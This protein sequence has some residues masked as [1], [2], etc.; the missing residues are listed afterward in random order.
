MIKVAMIGA[1]SVEFSKRLTGDILAYPEFKNATLTY[2]DIDQERLQVGAAL[3][4][5][6]AKTLGSN[7]TIEAT[8][9]LRQALNG[10]D[11]VITM[12]LVGGFDSVLADFEIPRKFG[13]RQ[14]I[15][16]TAGPAAVMKALRL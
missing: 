3:C 15:A 12:L 5:K 6:M 14:T 7:A 11:F 2:M 16:D 8:L 10:A 9:D 13:L 1:G 4:R